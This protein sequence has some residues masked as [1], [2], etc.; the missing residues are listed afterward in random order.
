M[1]SKSKEVYVIDVAMMNK[2]CNGDFLDEHKT[3]MVCH[4]NFIS[5]P[6]LATLH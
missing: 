3:V 5:Y 6:C 1:P 4:L 2:I